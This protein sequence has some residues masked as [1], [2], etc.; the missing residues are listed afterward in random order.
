[1]LAHSLNRMGNWLANQDQWDLAL[2]H[3][4]ES[5][6]IFVRDGNRPGEAATL[7]MAAMAAYLSGDMVSAT[8]F[9]A[10]ALPL[11]REL[12]DRAGQAGSFGLAAPNTHYD[13]DLLAGLGTLPEVI[14]HFK[15]SVSLARDLGWNA[16]EAMALAIL[17]EAWGASG[18][19][20]KSLDALEQALAIADTS[21]TSSGSSRRCGGWV[22][23]MSTSS[24]SRLHRRTSSEP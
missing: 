2:A 14:E 10:R 16:G 20:G 9:N 18:D 22:G 23:C 12:G 24:I 4:R 13:L 3:H 19:F 5:L 1:M 15:S 17:G 6:G 21:S 8:G 11:F 7:D